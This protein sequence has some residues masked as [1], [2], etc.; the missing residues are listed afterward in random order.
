MDTKE[1]LIGHLEEIQA[2]E[3]DQKGLWFWEKLGRLPFK[4]LDKMTPAFIQEK[5]GLLVS[6]LGSYIQTGGRYLISEEGM[7]KKIRVATYYPVQTI[8]EV[9]QIPLNNMIA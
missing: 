2:W 5:I 8:E 4:I 9:G 7:L 3:Q 6:E 1:Q